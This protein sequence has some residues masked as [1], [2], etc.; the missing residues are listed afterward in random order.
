MKRIYKGLMAFALAFTLLLGSVQSTFAVTTDSLN[1]KDN[2]TVSIQEVNEANNTGSFKVLCSGTQDRLTVYKVAAMNWNGTSFDEPMWVSEVSTWLETSDYKQYDTPSKLVSAAETVQG[3]FFKA[4][5]DTEKG[6]QNWVDE[7]TSLSNPDVVVENKSAD[8]TEIESYTVTNVPIGIYIAVGN[9]ETKTYAPAVANLIP[10]RAGETGKWYLD[11]DIMVSMKS[12]DAYMHKYI[13]G[14]KTDIVTIG[15]TVEFAIDFPLPQYEQRASGSYTLTFDDILSDSFTLDPESIVVKYRT[16]DDVDW[17]EFGTEDKPNVIEGEVEVAGILNK[18]LYSSFIAAPAPANN[19]NGYGITIWGCGYHHLYADTGYQY[20]IYRNKYKSETGDRYAYYYMQ[21]GAYHLLLDTNTPDE[22]GTTVRKA[23]QEATKDTQSHS[24]V[25]FLADGSSNPLNAGSIAPDTF[26]E[27]LGMT[28]RQYVAS[29]FHNVFNI[30]FDYAKLIEAGYNEKNVE[31]QITYKAEANQ[32]ILINEEANTN[33]ATMK[34]E[35]NSAGTAFATISDTVKAYT[36]ALNLVKM[37]GDTYQTTPK[38]DAEGKPLTDAEGKPVYEDPTYL[39]GAIFNVF[40][41]THAFVGDTKDGEFEY[42]ASMID[43]DKEW[44]DQAPTLTEYKEDHPEG[45]YYYYTY[46]VGNEAITLDNGATVEPGKYITRVFKLLVLEDRVFGTYCDGTIT[47]VAEKEGVMLK[48]LDEGNYIVSEKTAPAGYNT[49]AEDMMF[50]IYK[51]SEANAEK[52]GGSYA[53]FAEDKDGAMVDDDGVYNLNVLNYSGLTLPST[54]GMGTVLFTIIGILLMMSAIVVILIKGRQNVKNAAGY[55]AI[56]LIA[57]MMLTANPQSFYAVKEV[58]L[59]NSEYGTQ[60]TGNEATVSFNVEL[61]N[62]GEKIEAYKIAE[63]TWDSTNETYEGPKWVLGIQQGILG[64]K[65]EEYTTPAELATKDTKTQIEFLNWVYQN[66]DVNNVGTLPNNVAA[67]ISYSEDGLTATVKSVPYGIY[68]IKASAS[69]E[70]GDITKTYQL[71]TV[72]AIPTQEGPLG[73]WYIKDN[74]SAS[75]KFSDIIV[76]KTIN[77]KDGVTVGTDDEVEF[78]IKGEVPDYPGVDTVDAQ[79]NP[80]KDYSGYFFNFND[81]MSDAFEIDMKKGM[82]VEWSENGEDWHSLTKDTHYTSMLALASA[83]ASSEGVRSYKDS[84]GN[85]YLYAIVQKSATGTNYNMLWYVFNP[86]KGIYESITVSTAYNNIA[87]SNSKIANAT[88]TD[89]T[90]EAAYE[91]ATGLAV[92]STFTRSTEPK[93]WKDINN[94]S[95]NYEALRNLGAKYVRITYNAVVTPTAI[96]GT[97]DNT[98]TATFYYQKD[99]SGAGTSS[100]DTA[101]AWTYGLN[102][103][104]KDGDKV[105]TYLANARFK[106]YKEAYWYVP[107]EATA[108]KTAS[109]YDKYTFIKSVDDSTEVPTGIV[110]TE[111]DA[112][113]VALETLELMNA[114]V[115]GDTYFRYVDFNANTCN[116]ESCAK[117][118]ADHSHVLVYEL[119]EFERADGTTYA[120]LVTVNTAAGITVTGLAPA[121]YVLIETEAP[122]GYNKLQEVLR[123][124]IIELEDQDK[125]P[126]YTTTDGKASLRALVSDETYKVEEIQAEPTLPHVQIGEGDSAEYHKVYENGI[127]KIEVENFAGLVLPSTG[128]MGTLLFTLV[129]LFLMSAVLVVVIVKRKSQKYIEY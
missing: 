18:E 120:E 109:T 118:D 16:K 114:V 14:E 68:L 54:G 5:L 94:I 15:E 8:G 10:Q 76:E 41:E 65:F 11:Q 129:G 72:D 97:D 39:S 116:V 62:A 37:D 102:I 42:L 29:L 1:N 90:I 17:E 7:W 46:P 35:T 96:V 93:E 91:K 60:T 28:G 123:F 74:I 119:Y 53:L 38:V 79:G 108:D 122:S 111:T 52:N 21:D 56:L 26:Q 89:A 32:K 127:Y 63:L 77:G 34:Y 85:E 47:S 99:L 128:G 100:S 117:K 49:L 88:V 71:L 23:Y 64:T 44:E 61:K 81:T 36:Y 4:L 104:K 125:T 51:I 43:S 82:T 40:K 20:I 22:T 69:N 6:I 67:S 73:N 84:L 66:K 70:Q 24:W 101:Y 106:L 121:S 19:A 113:A 30:T 9:S 78:V 33:T 110:S 45:E 95:F 98:N 115:N 31:I 57:S 112:T 107:N 87:I 103:V 86:D 27:K 124:E 12:A 55:M 13:N 83:N 48:G 25:Q 80:Q 59:G 92:S 126:D 105:D 3:D 50:S 2:E 58:P 75:L